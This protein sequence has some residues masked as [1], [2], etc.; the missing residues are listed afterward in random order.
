MIRA[1][2]VGATTAGVGSRVGSSSAGGTASRSCSQGSSPSC[3]SSMRQQ[4][5]L[6][7]TA[8]ARCAAARITSGLASCGARSIQGSPELTPSTSSSTVSG[9][10]RI[11][12]SACTR[13][14][15][16]IFLTERSCCTK[17][18]RGSFSAQQFGAGR[19]RATSSGTAVRKGGC[20]RSRRRRSLRSS[21]P[22]GTEPSRFSIRRHD[23]IEA[24][25]TRPPPLVM[26]LLRCGPG[27]ARGAASW[28]SPRADGPAR[29]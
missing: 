10:L 21:A 18:S 11:A 19:R 1:E 6:P 24:A 23:G 29:A 2:S 7:D 26:P 5:S 13:S 9:S 3:S 17:A 15:R 27:A 14:L 4:R 16:R 22:A 25:G 8:R 28:R 20:W 12:R